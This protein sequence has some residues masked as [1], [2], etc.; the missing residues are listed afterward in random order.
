MDC[1]KVCAGCSQ[2][3][4]FTNLQESVRRFYKT[5]YCKA[6]RVRRRRELWAFNEKICIA[7]S[8]ENDNTDHGGYGGDYYDGLYE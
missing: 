5:T 3:P 2:F 7:Q 6:C 8:L 1:G 4:D